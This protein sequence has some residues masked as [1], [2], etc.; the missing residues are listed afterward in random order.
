MINSVIGIKMD[1]RQHFEE[2]LIKEC[3]AKVAN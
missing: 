3:K 1:N 2:G